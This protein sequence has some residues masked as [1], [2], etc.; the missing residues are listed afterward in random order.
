MQENIQEIKNVTG[1]PNSNWGH[2]SIITS[3]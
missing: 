3:V 1:C 2:F